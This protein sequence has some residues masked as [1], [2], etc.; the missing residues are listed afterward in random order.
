RA[1]LRA[2]LPPRSGARPRRG[3]R[4]ARAG[5]RAPHG[6]APR[7]PGVGRERRGRR[8]D[9][10]LHDAARVFITGSYGALTLGAMRLQ[11][12]IPIMLAASLASAD[13]TVAAVAAYAQEQSDAGRFSGVV[14]VAKSGKT[15]LSRAYGLAD[16]EARTPNTPET[17]FNVGSLN[18]QFTQAAIEQ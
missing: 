1:H 5:D 18:K 17:L 8:R 6:R 3:R 7:R 10:H 4:R 15:L 11:L 13:E 14:L 2:L 12:V 16:V 9:L